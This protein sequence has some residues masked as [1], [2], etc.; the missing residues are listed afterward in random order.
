MK[1]YRRK[2]SEEVPKVVLEEANDK[3]AA[4]GIWI[5][6]FIVI[7]VLGLAYY[8]FFKDYFITD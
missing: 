3:P 4:R 7:L 1:L 5:T 2:K 8:L 6:I